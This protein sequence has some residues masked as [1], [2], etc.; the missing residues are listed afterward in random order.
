MTDSTLEGGG[1]SATTAIGENDGVVTTSASPGASA[2]QE[3]TGFWRSYG[4][5]WA[6]VPAESGVL[7]VAFPLAVIATSVLWPLFSTG[8]GLLVLVVGF[9]LVLAS[10]YIARGYG[11][12]T[13][14]ML[15]GAGRPRI[16]RPVWRGR[17]GTG[18][19]GRVLSP[20][21]DGHYW[22]Y[23]LDA[24]V[25]QIAVT[26]LTW[27][28][29]ITWVSTALGG[30]TF[31]IWG[32]FLPTTGRTVWLSS[33]IWEWVTRT[34][35]TFDPVTADTVLYAV[36]GL[37]FL[38][39]LPYIT[40]ALITLHW[41][42]ARGLLGAWPSDRLRREVTELSAS[43]AAAVAAEDRELRRLE[44]DIHDGPQQQLIRLRMDIA[45]AQRRLADDPDATSRLLDEAGVR[46]QDALDEL[47]ALSRGFAP[48]IL[49]DRGLAAAIDSLAARSTIPVTVTNDVSTDVALPQ[50]VERNLYFVAAELLT[51]VAKHSRSDRARLTLALAG[52]AL[53]L[54]VSDDGVGGAGENPRHGL[55]GIRERVTAMRGTTSITSGPTGTTV[56]VSVPIS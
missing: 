27:S 2:A 18:F 21:A 20:L 45:A 43:R 32:G 46:A 15:E 4:R 47:R 19:I 40:R 26:T 41:S 25:V 13:L 24:I 37:V 9:F 29:F 51:N 12:M 48:P 10:L 3:G 38:F 17:V 14:A 50:E 42:V 22:I 34:P 28:I 35:A 49:Q 55:S 11:T 36:V 8:I 53:T 23:L 1:A 44:R 31:W 5:R 30:T 6:R 7:F 54:S 39:T 33:V 52:N 56:S 16:P